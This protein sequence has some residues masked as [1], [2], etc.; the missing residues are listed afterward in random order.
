MVTDLGSHGDRAL[1]SYDRNKEWLAKAWTLAEGHVLCQ[2]SWNRL[3]EIELSSRKVLAQWQTS[4]RKNRLWSAAESSD[5]SMFAITEHTETRD[6]ISGTIKE[7]CEEVP[8]PQIHVRSTSGLKNFAT[9]TG[10]LGRI[11]DL[12][13]SMDSATLFSAGNDGTI[14][15]WDTEGL[16]ANPA[17]IFAVNRGL[18]G[19]LEPDVV[20]I[21]VPA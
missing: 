19:G 17:I 12:A 5:G 2:I 20:G 8:A 9:L 10:H 11:N 6:R 4:E 3:V 21:R 7:D 18:S 16:A 1:Y 15:V 14:R 13:F